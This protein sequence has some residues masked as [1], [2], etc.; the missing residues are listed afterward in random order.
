M[1]AV[2]QAEQE[3]L[4]FADVEELTAARVLDNIAPLVAERADNQLRPTGWDN[5]DLVGHRSAFQGDRK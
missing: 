4:L 1:R 5:G 3:L 2:E